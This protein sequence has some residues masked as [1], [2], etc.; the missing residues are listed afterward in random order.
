VISESS[1]SGSRA[2]SGAAVV[3]LRQAPARFLAEAWSRLVALKGGEAEA[4]EALDHPDPA[5]LVFIRRDNLSRGRRSIEDQQQGR[6]DE[7]AYG[8]TAK[9]KVDLRSL[10]A[11]RR[12]LGTGLYVGT[13][14]R[15]DIPSELWESAEFDFTSGRI[16]SGKFEYDAVTLREPEGSPAD[17]DKTIRDWLSD[18]RLQL[19]DEK[20]TVLRDAARKAF[21]DTFTVR[22]F[23][24]AY[25]AVYERK[26]GRPEKK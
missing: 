26:R 6:K 10:G 21:G 22:A 23:N 5:F 16:T 17:L 2:S 25:S 19:G 8:L 9:I 20:K 3:A 1:G 4:I 11:E 18:R 14:L 7:E 15:Q 13:G 24:A 12:F